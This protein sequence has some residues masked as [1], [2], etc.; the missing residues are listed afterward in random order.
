MLVEQQ[1]IFSPLLEQ[2]DHRDFVEEINTKVGMVN[3]ELQVGGAVSRGLRGNIL[4]FY[5]FCM[6][7]HNT[8]TWRNP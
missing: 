8:R 3:Q 5:T 7:Q 2:L 6:G 4:V 1:H